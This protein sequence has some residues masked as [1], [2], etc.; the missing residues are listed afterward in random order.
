M[1]NILR[2]IWRLTW[3]AASGPGA[4]RGL[5][6]YGCVLGLQFLGV[7]ISVRMIAWNKAFYDALEQL[8]AGAALR[9]IG[10]FAAL[11]AVSA[12]VFLLGEWLRKR[13]LIR[14]RAR[15]TE[16]ALDLWVG[17]RAYWHLRPGFATAPVDNPDQ[18]VAED[19]RL[20]INRLLLETLDL[21]SNIVALVSYVA[22]LWSLSEFALTFPLFG[23]EIT[24]PRYMVIAAFL[25][26]ALSTIAT[27]LLGRPLK[28]LIFA[29]EKREADFRHALIQLREDA[30]PIA[31]AGGE[32]AERRR[33]DRLF[34]AIRGNWRALIRAELVLGLFARPYFQTVLRIPTFLALPAYFAGAVTLGGLMQL[35]SAFSN[36]TTTLSWFIF[37]YRE[38]AEFVA[39]SER[40]DG[41]FSAARDPA[42]RDGIPQELQHAPAPDNRL[43]LSAVQLFTPEGRALAPVPDL[44]LAPGEVIWLTGASGQGKSTL[45]AALAGLWPYG[46]G[47]IAQPPGRLTCLPQEARPFPE[48]L[49]AAATYPDPVGVYGAQTIYQAL[50][51]IGLGHLAEDAPLDALSGGERQRLALARALLTRPDWLLLDEATSALDPG[52]ETALLALL[53]RRLPQT[54]I[55]CIAHRPPEAL[56]PYRIIRIG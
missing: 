19:C 24:I 31:Q 47:R 44:D 18:R 36:V 41:L 49:H 30:G 3:L 17:G 26:V 4:W 12:A 9:Q 2:R 40:L 16:R 1:K 37:S 53:R 10:I 34:G 50:A 45:L 39:V 29:Q 46:R 51:E 55:L 38:L 14:W 48:G 54:A 42:R 56:A 28:G 52:A 32:A 25:Y 13:L 7:W 8:D 33:L 43:R 5:A 21:I 15:L 6:T 23:A 22:L 11:I 35:A 20:F 27:H